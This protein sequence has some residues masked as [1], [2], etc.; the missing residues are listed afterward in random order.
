MS[1]LAPFTHEQADYI[2]KSLDSWFNVIEGGK[3]GSKNIVNTQAFG[4]CVDSHEDNLFLAGGY[5]VASA[6]LN[7]ID[8]N[9]LGLTHYFRGRCKEGKYKDRDCLRVYT[10]K[11]EKIIL[12]SGGGKKGDEKLIQGNTYGAVLITEANLCCQEFIKET[13]DRTM[14]SSARKIF[15]DLNPKAPKHWYY[16]EV[17]NFH[18]QKQKEN[19]DYGFNYL[20][21][22]IFDNMSL[23]NAQIRTILNTYDKTS[24][25]YK[26]DILGLRTN[27]EGGVFT[28][29]ANNPKRWIIDKP[30]KKYTALFVGVDFGGNISKTV[31]TLSGLCLN[32]KNEPEIHIL[33]AHKVIEKGKPIDSSQISKE[34]KEFF[35]NAFKKYGIYPTCSFTDHNMKALTTQLGKDIGDMSKVIFVDKSI[36]LSEWCMYVNTCFNLD[37]IKIMSHC[38]I[39]IDSLSGL[40]YDSKAEEDI[41]L[42]DGKTCD[43]DTY[44]SV[45]Y[46]ISQIIKQWIYYKKI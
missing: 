2:I 37:K 27:A 12:I 42:D 30:A 39:V 36:S 46:S 11:G 5:S 29:F 38:Q 40:I 19:K 24:I 15:H 14:S 18:E 35:M 41:P 9:G 23:S 22:N 6:K 21:T 45:R 43:I 16:E 10:R 8:S 34:H 4:I 20:Q 33:E 31:F 7:I 44:D 26:R 32:E 3:R 25:W 1:S 17:I 28:Q 13:F